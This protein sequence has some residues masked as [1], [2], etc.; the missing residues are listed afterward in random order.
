MSTQYLLP[1][2]QLSP[3]ELTRD[4][5]LENV[6]VIVKG[7]AKSWPAY[8]KWTADYF[9]SDYGD[10]RVP[11][12]NYGKN[13]FQPTNQKPTIS[14]KD[15]LESALKISR[16]ISDSNEQLYS[17]SWYF[18][19]G[20]C[21]LLKDVNIPDCFKENW[22]EKV[23][24]VF[25]FDYRAI[26]FGH[27]KV[28][29]PLHTDSFFVSTWIAMIRGQKRI[30]LVDP[31]YTEHV[32]N[33]FDVFNDTNVATLTQKDVPIYDGIV[34]EGDLVWF[35]PGW[36][37]YVK[38]DTFTISIT[39]NHVAA[40]NF[41]AFE[42]QFRTVILKPLLKLD[43]VKS[44]FMKNPAAPIHKVLSDSHFIQNEKQYL[45]YIQSKFIHT[46]QILADLASAG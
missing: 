37:H 18:C 13:P 9:M 27:P 21:E 45:N 20:Y 25:A 7:I 24:K 39:T 22:A 16:G 10:V 3:S 4:I 12:S 29:S 30:R 36:W 23:Q 40:E 14:I 28:G 17:S 8:Q 31:T 11:L 19:R 46:E 42:Q 38:N 41:L 32:H 43:A 26:L 2:K 34:E 33:G 1:I 6:P 35:P 44:D 15:Y 5:I